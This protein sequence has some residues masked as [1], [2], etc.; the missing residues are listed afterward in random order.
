MVRSIM[1]V[2]SP[3]S[4]STGSEDDPDES[5]GQLSNDIF[6]SHRPMA[7]LSDHIGSVSCVALCGEFILS[8]SQ[9]KDIIVW[10]QP[11]LRRFTKFGNG[12]GLVKAIVAVGNQLFTAHQDCKIRVWKVSTKSK[13]NFR[14]SSILPT[15]KDYYLAK[16]IN[17]TNYVRTRQRHYHHHYQTHKLWIEH[18]DSISCLLVHD[19]M[20]YSGSWD[21]TF[22]VWRISDLKCMESIKAH[23]DVI[24]GLVVDSFG[25][26]Y[27]ASA[28][29][30]IKLW[31]KH[32][33]GCHTLKGELMCGSGN[34]H[35]K[36]MAWNCVVINGGYVYG[37]SSDGF[38]MGWNIMERGD[39]MGLACDVK[40]HD[41]AVL[42]MC[43]IAD[44]VCC[45]SVDST[46]SVWKRGTGCGLLKKIGVIGGHEG[47]V[48]CLEGTCSSRGDNGWFVLYSGGLD[49]SLRVWWVAVGDRPIKS[50]APLAL[51]CSF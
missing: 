4:T 26:L 40:A 33:N 12:E 43:S 20:L 51:L 31:E 45:G 24:N 39:E 30:L 36:E 10:Q 1:T 5:S 32:S 34:G 2:S 35:S 14:L 38:V 16:F 15:T 8:A 50:R 17:K 27:S 28:D 19:G 41:K 22:K 6:L 21:K 47:P 49:K 48:K 13:N 23:D 7:V 29:G 42:C 11:V 3:T 18:T 37:G 46:I 9:S 44:V 25:V